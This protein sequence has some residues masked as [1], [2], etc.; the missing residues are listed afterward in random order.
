MACAVVTGLAA[1]LMVIGRA[2]LRRVWLRVRPG[3]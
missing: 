1:L 2:L 3:R